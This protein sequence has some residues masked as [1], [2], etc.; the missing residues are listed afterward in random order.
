LFTVWRMRLVRVGLGAALVASTKLVGVFGPGIPVLGLLGT[1]S[2]SFAV[3]SALF[4]WPGL[5]GASALHAVWTGSRSGPVA[6]PLV[7]TVLYALAGAL[8][9]LVF[10]KLDHVGRAFPNLRSL[11]WFCA[12]TGVGGLLTSLSL[13]LIFE[14]STFWS[15]AAVW[16]RSTVVSVW[17]FGPALLI[18]GKRLPAAWLAP[19][20][21]E[22]EDPARGRFTLR[23]VA[24][25]HEME[26]V[27]EPDPVAGLDVLV[28]AVVLTFV[29]G[30]SL[31]FGRYSEGAGHW[32]AL[33][34]LVPIY[35]ATRRHRLVGGLV[36]AGGTGLAL[37]LSE[38]IEHSHSAELSTIDR[39]LDVYV[40]LLVFLAVGALLGHARNR[41][42]VL[43]EA[44][45]GSNQRLRSDLNRVVRALTGAVEAKD[46]YTEGHLQR[47]SS[48]A[49]E[50]GSLLGLN[51]SE[52]G[53]LRIASALHDVGK[54]G[55]PEHIL[56][57]PGPL[58]EAER[59]IIERHPEI[60]A[61]I[62]DAVDGLSPAAPLVLHHQERWD[63]RREGRY[64]GYPHGIRGGEIPLGARIIAVV[65]AFDAMTTDRAYRRALPL[66][67]A[68]AE[69]RGERG[70]QFDP[71]VVDAFLE[72][73]DRQ[74][75]D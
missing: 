50:V 30:V 55:V 8:V 17:V 66:D 34:Y 11:G 56:N 51:A 26:V 35:W 27:R 21:S 69:L 28:G 20:P 32:A 58:D 10:Q 65:D 14:T 63:G 70:G 5:V 44:L 24:L 31:L 57:K 12:A 41:E 67:E 39:Q 40:Y 7:S 18:L 3:G 29:A 36:A 23:G 74:P 54:I 16:S 25:D 46:V 45:R 15:S 75:W 37:V 6:Y 62:L 43:L 2:L 68:V 72:I 49:L 22:E 47:V 52:L 60:G 33:F 1:T 71:R 42:V 38:A 59:A 53:H 13:S 19:I 64:P 61:R 73:L 4:G 48:Y 9:I